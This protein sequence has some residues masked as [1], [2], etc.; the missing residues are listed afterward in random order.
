MILDFDTEALFG[1]PTQELASLKGRDYNT[2]DKKTNREFI[3]Y[4]YEQL[5]CRSFERRIKEAETNFTPS[6]A[7]SLDVDWKI[8]AIAA[9]KRCKKKPMIKL[10][11]PFI[12]T[13]HPLGFQPVQLK[14][15]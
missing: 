8:S 1:N 14:T 10:L 12:R 15:I 9:G 3:E 2:R 4:R 7:E 6:L 11:I 5:Q 13:L